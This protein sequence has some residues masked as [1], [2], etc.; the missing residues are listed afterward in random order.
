MRT[1]DICHYVGAKN[2]YLAASYYLNKG[3]QVYWPSVQ[4]EAVDFVVDLDGVLM[5]VQVKTATWIESGG[6]KYL[7]CRTRLTNK[8]Q[9]FTPSELYDILFVVGPEGEMWEIDPGLVFSSNLSLKKSS[10]KPSEW[11]NYRVN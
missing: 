8:R 7:Q 9:G 10:G 6:K 3:H 11:D 1:T 2:E 5:K 4:Q